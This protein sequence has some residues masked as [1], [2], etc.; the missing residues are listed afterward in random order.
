[1]FQ[2]KKKFLSLVALSLL[3]FPLE[4]L[5]AKNVDCVHCG[6]TRIEVNFE[7]TNV[8]VINTSITQITDELSSS[9]GKGF[10][11]STVDNNYICTLLSNPAPKDE[12][13]L[14]M[15]NNTIEKF[16]EKYKFQ[17]FMQIYPSIHC[18]GGLTLLSTTILFGNLEVTR[19]L[20]KMHVPLNIVN[21]YGETEL[22]FMLRT[23]KTARKKGI[24]NLSYIDFFT[25][26]FRGRKGK[27]YDVPL[28]TCE[29]E[30]KCKC[31]FALPKYGE[32]CTP[33]QN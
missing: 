9:R 8:E 21:Q 26:V 25:R 12:D 29:I 20:Y 19:Q 1:M 10:V 32:E 30:G 23:V 6:R 18:L 3:G 22:D 2:W 31:P 17:D 4:A 5:Q 13:N 7:G 27:N 16:K 28:L 14:T 15:F 33:P 24:T 11:L